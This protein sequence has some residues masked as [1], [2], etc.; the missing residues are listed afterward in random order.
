MTPRML[1]ACIDG[2]TTRQRREQNL[3]IWTAWHTAALVRV[4]R[5]PKLE[6]MLRGGRRRQRQ[7]PAQQGAAML[8]IARY[9]GAPDEQIRTAKARMAEGGA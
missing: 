1:Q 4:K 3:A 2:A 8:A 5:L 6:R 7:T 9:F